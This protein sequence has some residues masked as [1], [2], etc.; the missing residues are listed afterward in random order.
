M[1]KSV[2]LAPIT[3]GEPDELNDEYDSK[4]IE[5][6]PGVPRRNKQVG[7]CSVFVTVFLREFSKWA[8]P[9]INNQHDTLHNN[10]RESDEKHPIVSPDDRAIEDINQ[11]G[12]HEEED[13]GVD[14]LDVEYLFLVIHN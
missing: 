10:S 2:Q 7:Y 13:D 1:G 14:E 5:G 8:C 4:Y 6:I 9:A 11:A 12:Y 3:P